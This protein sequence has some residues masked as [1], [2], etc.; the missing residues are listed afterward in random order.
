MS[1]VETEGG[2]T[3]QRAVVI[4]GSIA[5]LLTGQALSAAF[6]EVVIIDR[7]DVDTTSTGVRRGV[8]QARH[9]HT[10]LRRGEQILNT[11][12]PGITDDLIRHGAVV[13]PMG[14]VWWWQHRGYR[15]AV[16][17]AAPIVS[18]SRPLLEF[19]VRERVGGNG[20]VELRTGE[21]VGLA[22]GD[23]AVGGVR[24]RDPSGGTTVLDAALVVDCSGRRSRADHWLTELGHPCPDVQLVQ[25]DVR[26]TTRVFHRSASVRSDGAAGYFVISH[27]R[28]RKRFGTAM[29]IEGDRWIITLAGLHGEGAPADLAGYLSWARTLPT[30]KIAS[31]VEDERPIGAA[32]RHRLPGSEWRLYHRLAAHPRGF[33]CVGDSVCSLN[34]LY[35]QGMTSAAVQVVAL[36]QALARCD[37][38]APE[39]ARTFY[40]LSARAVSPAWATAAGADFVYPE[41]RG[42]RPWP[43]KMINRYVTR[44]VVAGQHDP[45]VATRLWDVANM[46]ASPASLLS[47]PALARMVRNSRRRPLRNSAPSMPR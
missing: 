7:D 34:A 20:V 8:P 47:P 40:R 31:I 4:G 46:V 3:L 10:L 5:G 26:Y 29:P 44:C 25:S 35:G 27:P 18:C 37:V 9:P 22:G 23:G 33:V 17:D 1:A 13:M 30:A 2:V 12:F 39:F 41:T 14:R 45:A 38:M 11:L 32:V 19:L 43:T 24:V 16:P 21:A 42:H 15:A 36:Q 28:A 6:D